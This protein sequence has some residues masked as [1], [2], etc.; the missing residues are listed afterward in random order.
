M[1]EPELHLG[2]QCRRAGLGCLA[3]RPVA[4]VL[5]ETAWISSAP[6][7]VC[8]IL[9]PSTERYDRGDKRIIYA[10]AGVGHLW[11]VDPVLRMLEVFELRDGKWLLLDVYRRQR[12]RG[13]AAVR[14]CELS[15]RAAV[16][17]RSTY[18]EGQACM[19]ATTTLA[20]PM[21]LRG[22]PRHAACDQAGRGAAGAGLPVRLLHAAWGDDGVR[23]GGAGG[24]RDRAGGADDL[25]VR[26]AHRHQ[27]D[28]RALRHVRRRDAGGR[29]QGVVGAQRARA[30]HPRVRGAR[31]RAGRL[32]WRDAGCRIARR[33]PKWTPTEIVWR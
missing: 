22:D 32:R 2:A 28:L 4:D 5:P 15:A 19:G 31:G 21:P 6:D 9:S 10:E 17:V 7:W 27:P 24:I 1:D 8:E 11:H 16:A 18:A 23:S 30:W 33:K 29:R 26:H 3:A 20:R 13:G 25:P 12:G 14:G